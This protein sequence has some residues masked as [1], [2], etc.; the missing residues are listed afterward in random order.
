LIGSC[1]LAGSFVK[2][3]KVINGFLVP[4]VLAMRLELIFHHFEVAVIG[5]LGSHL[6]LSVHPLGRQESTSGILVN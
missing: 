6:T 3:G 4:H 5:S 1:Y 2:G